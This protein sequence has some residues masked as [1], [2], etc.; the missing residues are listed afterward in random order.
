MTR[1]LQESAQK[2]ERLL[3]TTE[4]MPELS[5]CF[6]YV[7]KGDKTQIIYTRKN[8]EELT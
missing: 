4:V 6:T 5:K 2:R 8:K 1:K 3:Y 7:L